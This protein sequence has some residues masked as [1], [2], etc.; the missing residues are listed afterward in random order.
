MST[1]DINIYEKV[2]SV[3]DDLIND[4]CLSALDYTLA[5]DSVDKVQIVNEFTV[6]L[7]N[8]SLVETKVLP[9]SSES[10]NQSSAGIHPENDVNQEEK[11]VTP[12]SELKITD[13]NDAAVE[14]PKMDSNDVADETE[15]DDSDENDAAALQNRVSYFFVALYNLI[16]CTYVNDVLSSIKNDVIADDV[17][18]QLE[19]TDVDDITAKFLTNFRI[20]LEK[21]LAERLVNSDYSN[22][23]V[24]TLL[25]QNSKNI[26]AEQLNLLEEFR[27]CCMQREYQKDVLASKVLHKIREIRGYRSSQLQQVENQFQLRMEKLNYQLKKAKHELMDKYY[28]DE[29]S[30][31]DNDD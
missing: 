12:L 11:I 1:E 29:S 10:T 16:L 24:I 14:T 3:V 9:D 19:D 21:E 25:T 18:E 23:K 28:D 20:P 15:D 13:N 27:V 4:T 17:E 30:G 8:V 22:E 7:D 5:K 2:K 26:S 31:D 6:K